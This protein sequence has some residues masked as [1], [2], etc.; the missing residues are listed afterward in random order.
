MNLT[1]NHEQALLEAQN[2]TQT[3]LLMD[4][5][6]LPLE[7]SRPHRALIVCAVAS[8][9]GLCSWAVRNRAAITNRILAKEH[10]A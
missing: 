1:L 7:K 9:A 2:D 5:G 3:L 10:S 4:P 6:S 8:A